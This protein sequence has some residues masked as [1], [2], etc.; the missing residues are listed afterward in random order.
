VRNLGVELEPKEAVG[1]PRARAG[2][3]LAV[4][5]LADAHKVRWQL[6]N[7]VSMGHPHLEDVR[8]ARK[9][10]GSGTLHRGLAHLRVAELAVRRLCDATAEL[11]RHL[12][13]PIAN[14][15]DG[16][17][18]LFRELPNGHLRGRGTVRRLSV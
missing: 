6:V 17:P 16:E 10:L 14:A 11:V 18:A 8:Q 13:K 1:A 3:E 12:L 7:L 4:T 2:R 9:E 5:R 15:Q